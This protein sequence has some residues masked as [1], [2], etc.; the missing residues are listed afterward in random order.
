M[1]RTGRQNV[2]APMADDAL[3]YQGAVAAAQLLTL[4]P[5]RFVVGRRHGIRLLQMPAQQTQMV[6]AGGWIEPATA[7][8]VPKVGL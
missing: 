3:L 6:Q 7:V 2:C 5:C 4:Q 8:S 1:A